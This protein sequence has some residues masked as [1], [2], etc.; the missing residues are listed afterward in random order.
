MTG[1]PCTCQPGPQRNN[2]NECEGTGMKLD[3]AEI[4]R[5]TPAL[6]PLQAGR[7]VSTAPIRKFTLG[8]ICMT[9][10]AEAAILGAGLDVR[11][12]GAIL[13]RHQSGDF[14]ELDA[15]DIKTQNESL[16]AAASN[17]DYAE[18]MM[19]VYTL[20]GVKLWVI[21]EWDRSVTTILL[22]EDY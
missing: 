16:E 10:A 21:T 11:A 9:R 7:T 4:R 14:G 15:G 12:F 19:S 13:L 2:C 22:P 8:Q 20:A 18:R 1:E 17:P 5:R 3:F 6:L